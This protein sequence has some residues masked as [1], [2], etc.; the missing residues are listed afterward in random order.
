MN[1]SLILCLLAI[2]GLM[3]ATP[4]CK[5]AAEALQTPADQVEIATHAD[6]DAMVADVI[7]DITTDANALIEADASLSGDASVVDEV[8]CDASVAL[9]TESDP[10][11][12]T[13]TFNG[14]N[15]GKHTRNGA[16][17]LSMPKGTKWKDAGAAITIQYENFA[18]TRKSDGK[19]I[20]LNGTH[21]YTNVSGGLVYHAASLDS[22]VHT[23][24]SENLSIKFDDETAR[25]WNMSRKKEFT[26]DNGLVISVS[27]MH[28][29]EEESNVADWGTNRFGKEF[30]TSITSPIVLKQDCD[31]RVSAG[32]IKHKTEVFT[33][34]ATFG[35]D[36]SGNATACPG[37]GKYYYRLEWSRNS[38]GNSFDLILPY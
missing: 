1:K 37:S 12:A 23:L 19:T 15:C 17:V 8:I 34:T 11:T 38:N 32:T 28:N 7:D 29:T 10:M 22:I 3:I 16:V 21:I 18:I 25:N 13:V 9:D 30:T 24:V 27:G 4:G 35:L 31:F 26:Y 14:A 36:A 33:S 6:D 2:S 5:K 20:V